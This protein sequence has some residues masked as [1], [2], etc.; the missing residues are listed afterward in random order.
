MYV[1]LNVTRTMRVITKVD[2]P[3]TS[4]FQ[5]CLSKSPTG[6]TQL[7]QFCGDARDIYRDENLTL[8]RLGI[9]RARVLDATLK[10]GDKEQIHSQP[11]YVIYVIEAGS[12]ACI[13]LMELLLRERVPDRRRHV[14]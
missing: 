13:V 14:S 6:P 1:D 5:R 11:A 7:L 4:C 12:S 2:Y 3:Q 10:T 9:S 8:A